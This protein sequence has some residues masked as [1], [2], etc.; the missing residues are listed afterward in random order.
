MPCFA[1]RLRLTLRYGQYRIAKGIASLRASLRGF[2][3]ACMGTL[4]I[5]TQY[6][7]ALLLRC[8]CDALIRVAMRV[9]CRFAQRSVRQPYGR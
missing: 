8:C 1:T 3:I 6:S 5:A 9:V 7:V 4:R 2:A